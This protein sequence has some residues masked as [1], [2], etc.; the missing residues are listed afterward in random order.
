VRGECESIDASYRSAKCLFGIRGETVLKAR[1][2]AWRRTMTEPAM[3]LWRTAEGRVPLSD[4]RAGA[5]VWLLPLWSRDVEELAGGHEPGL[6]CPVL[7][8]FFSSA[9]S[10][11]AA[12]LES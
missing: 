1:A 7:E 6:R 12:R 4:P 5:L 2:V 10:S 11:A 8:P 3:W 9:H